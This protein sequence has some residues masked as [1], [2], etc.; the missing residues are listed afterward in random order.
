MNTK[1]IFE[2][3][4]FMN[5]CESV[6]NGNITYNKEIVKSFDKNKTIRFISFVQSINNI[7]LNQ[8]GLR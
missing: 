4:Q 6:L 8:N 7:E 3:E 1:R 5:I 2:G